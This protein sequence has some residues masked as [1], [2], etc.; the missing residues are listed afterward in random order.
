MSRWSSTSGRE[1]EVRAGGRGRV[2]LFLQRPGVRRICWKDLDLRPREEVG[3]CP[4]PAGFRGFV[5]AGTEVGN[6]G[7]RGCGE[8]EEEE[9]GSTPIL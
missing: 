9:G 7:G 2:D 1:G 3:V 4:S 6:F 5:I 8:E